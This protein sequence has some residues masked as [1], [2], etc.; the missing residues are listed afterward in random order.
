MCY[1]TDM[2][3]N[4]MEK[5]LLLGGSFLAGFALM[6]IELLAVRIMAPL[7][8]ASVYTWTSAIGMT[9]LGL[10]VG[11]YA[12]GKIAD[13]F[14]YKS[15]LVF[16]FA[17][18]AVTV[19]FIPLL[20]YMSSGLLDI[21]K[22]ILSLNLALSGTLFLV[23]ALFLGT[24]QPIVVKLYSKDYG[25]LGE[26]YGSLS[27]LWSAGSILGVF[28]TG[29]YFAAH[30]GSLSILYGI[31]GTLFA[32]GA[33]FFFFGGDARTRKANV[34]F[35]IL[36][37]ILALSVAAYNIL[38][39]SREDTALYEKSSAYYH[40]KVVDALFAQA[41]QSRFLFLDADVHSIEPE[42][43]GKTFLYTDIYPLFGAM[44]EDIRTIYVIGGG[45]YTLP[46]AFARYY[47]NATVS[48][49]EIDREVE[50]VAKRFFGLDP[51]IIRTDY[52]DP[53]Y[54]F[55]VSDESYDLIFGDAYNSFVSVPGHL[56][57]HE[58]NE[59][60]KKHLNPGGIYALNIA[61]AAEGSGALLFQ[62]V[63]KTFV[64]TF[65][66]TAVVAFSSN[67]LLFQNIVLVGTTSEKPID[68]DAISRAL[69]TVF[70]E[71]GV[72]SARVVFA[73]PKQNADNGVF[74]TDDFMPVE[75]LMIPAVR[76]YFG[77]YFEFYKKFLGEKIFLTYK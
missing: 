2:A 18:A 23:P 19:S 52:R 75:N 63:Y 68:R 45:A 71:A 55:R 12:G 48:V 73:D 6:V 3:R 26:E 69:N 43:G 60:V 13:R 31:T 42:T 38:L 54:A 51:Q 14:P 20:G 66:N 49:S 1:N 56:L 28:L 9:L 5:I 37:L 57:T 4:T 35:Y 25:R 24:I 10:S 61:S 16:A 67:P 50:G 27:A 65:P 72:E 41:G 47:P 64:K 77:S 53:R 58:F 46:K 7:V 21:Y 74:L 17:A 32:L 62:S 30:F 44:K 39:S 33:T 76:E 15:T 59:S 36:L 8:G 22:G 34:A 70:N 11:S 29:F 40:I